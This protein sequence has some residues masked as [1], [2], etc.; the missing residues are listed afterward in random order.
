MRHHVCLS[1]VLSRFSIMQVSCIFIAKV[2]DDNHSE[3]GCIIDNVLIC[4]PTSLH[5][6]KIIESVERQKVDPLFL[7]RSFKHPRSGPC[8]RQETRGRQTRRGQRA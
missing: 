8:R 1:L 3:S 2:S 4:M 6:V 5:P 7:M